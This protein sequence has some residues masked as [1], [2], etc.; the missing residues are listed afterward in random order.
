MPKHTF[1]FLLLSLV[2]FSQCTVQKRVHR[3]GWHITWHKSHSKPANK[4]FNEEQIQN[5]L[6]FEQSNEDTSSVETPEIRKD[7]INQV[8][9]SNENQSEEKTNPSNP[10]SSII[11]SKTKSDWVKKFVQEELK[12]STK[13]KP[14]WLAVEKTGMIILL[15]LL[16]LLASLIFSVILYKLY[17]EEH[18]L[19]E[20]ITRIVGL[21]VFAVIA[22]CLLIFLLAALIA[23]SYE[24][25]QKRKAKRE[26]AKELAKQ[27]QTSSSTPD[28]PSSSTE[29][30]ENN[31][32]STQT[33]DK[34]KTE[35]NSIKRTLIAIG[36]G[37]ALIA[38]FMFI[39]K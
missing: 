7:S 20:G 27:K 8:I 23:P 11:K 1:F 13:P 29:S 30:V 3:S 9:H 37:I 36:I 33:E 35:K 21:V 2:L 14:K 38:A 26:K 4:L 5:E 34:P 19:I 31:E 6:S 24:G 39:S 18:T 17:H 28:S 25:Q 32:T 12:K 22:A 16:F 10:I 15:S